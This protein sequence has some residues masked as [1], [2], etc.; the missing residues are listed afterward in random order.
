M[1]PASPVLGW[2]GSDVTC[3][4]DP[5]FPLGFAADCPSDAARSSNSNAGF[6]PNDTTLGDGDGDTWSL[7]A[8]TQT[9]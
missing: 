9:L 4:F 2:Q 7:I 5:P 3:P 6:D 1:A 8:S